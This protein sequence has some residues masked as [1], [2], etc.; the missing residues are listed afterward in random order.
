MRLLR[1][2]TNYSTYLKQFYA[3]QPDM[4][5][6]S[7]QEQF[8]VLMADCFGWFDVWTN[9]L[10]PL[11]YEVWEPVGNA[12]PMQKRWAQEYGV[13]YDEETWLT[14]IVTA[15]V[16][17]FAPD[18][19]LV[20][21]YSTYTASFFQHLR[22]QCP[23]IQMVVGWCGAPYRDE[24]VFGS[25]DLVLSNIPV[26]VDRFRSQ[27]HRSEHMAHAF[28][29]RVLDRIDTGAGSRHPFTFVGSIVKGG[30]FHNRRERL[31][32]DLI[33][34]TELAI[35]SAVQ[36]P[37]LS[38]QWRHRTRQAL[39][40]ATQ[41]VKRVPGGTTILDA[42]PRLNRLADKDGPPSRRYVDSHIA[43]RAEPP[44]Y[45]TAMFQALHDSKIALNT[46]I[47]LSIDYAS[48]MRLFEATGVGT[49][50][51]TERQQNLDAL[52]TPDQE[53][54]TYGSAEEAVE[55][56]RYLLDHEDERRRI[57]QAG[58]RRTLRDH[59]FEQ[60]AQQLNALIREYL[61]R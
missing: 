18:V 58:Q 30:E 27:G 4:A 49:C 28:D 59:T 17:H 39:Y 46:H 50:L 34:K 14:T 48:N 42:V 51:L 43:A 5:D 20:N 54:V 25:Y 36:P 7:Y 41:H 8:D 19:V 60:R 29:P 16:E 11:G 38:Q 47:D 33:D 10:E 12:E 6:A 37:P 3:R 40:R 56:V 2:C 52:F 26:L 45:G 23:S 53:V 21:D 31:L 55:K 57:A 24:S 35:R 32:R 9:A 1:I 22:E 61:A 13:T 44:V 15:Q